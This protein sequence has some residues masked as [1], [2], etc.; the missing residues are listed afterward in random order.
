MGLGIPYTIMFAKGE[1]TSI[2][3]RH[4][5]MISLL[6]ATITTVLCFTLF[7]FIINRFRSTKIHGFVLIVLYSI[8]L[9][10]AFLIE[11]HV[12]SRNTLR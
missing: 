6:Y 1:K 8:Y 9:L 7:S 4:T 5:H 11:F 10:F 2:V 12:I 3:V